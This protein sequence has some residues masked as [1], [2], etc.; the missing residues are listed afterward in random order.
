MVN[1][2]EL[3]VVMKNP[4]YEM[5]KCAKCG[6]RYSSHKASRIYECWHCWKPE[7]RL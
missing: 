1:F 3:R 5:R 6:D 7:F 2:R 4:E